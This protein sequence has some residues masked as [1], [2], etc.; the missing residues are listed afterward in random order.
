MKAT[1]EEIVQIHEVGEKMAKNV[2]QFFR[3]EQTMDMIEKLRNAGVNFKKLSTDRVVDNRF[4]GYTFVLTGTLEK[5][6]RNEASTII[7]RYGGKV[8]GSVSKKTAFVLA[9]K[10]AGSKL[11]KAHKLGIKV[12]DEHQFEEMIR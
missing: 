11:D 2:V 9:G 8:T 1:V 6:T 10:E 7:E 4:E 5:Y 12:I 3:Q